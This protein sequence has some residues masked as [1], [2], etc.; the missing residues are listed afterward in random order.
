MRKGSKALS[1]KTFILV[2]VAA[3]CLMA[4]KKS[5]SISPGLFGKWE[6]RS[7]VGGIAGFDST[8]AAGNGRI[9][10]FNSDS[11]YKQF[12]K[13]KLLA[14]GVFHIVKNTNPNA[15][16]IVEIQFDHNTSGEFFSLQGTQLTIGQDVDDGIAMSY[17][18]IQNE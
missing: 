4:C 11:T 2:I 14:Q 1:M 9:Y 13:S 16:S 7:M 17:A 6:L 12:N 15:N 3:C 5:A 18:K 8:Y 10:Q